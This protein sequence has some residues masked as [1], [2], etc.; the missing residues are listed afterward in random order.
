MI[1]LKERIAR[2]HVALL[3][4][5]KEKKL[6]NYKI[7]KVRHSHLLLFNIIRSS[8]RFFWLVMHYPEVE[9]KIIN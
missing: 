4:E 7:I 1:I 3:D 8:C 2:W 6:L 9:D 5:N